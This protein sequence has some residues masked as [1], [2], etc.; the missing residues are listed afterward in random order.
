MEYEVCV[1][2]CMYVCMYVN[3]YV[4]CVELLDRPVDLLQCSRLRR[5]CASYFFQSC[6]VQVV[7]TREDRG[8]AATAS[9]LYLQIKAFFIFNYA[10][11]VMLVNS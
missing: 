3:T 8:E 6:L 1:Y 9:L 10:M 4:I 11:F 2:V 7:L 5:R